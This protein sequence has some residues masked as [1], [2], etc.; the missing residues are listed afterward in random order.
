M[1]YMYK[2]YCLF[3]YTYTKILYMYTKY[4]CIKILSWEKKQKIDKISR[5]YETS[6]NNIHSFCIILQAN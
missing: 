2:K 1:L 5:L 4:I 3:F 6:I